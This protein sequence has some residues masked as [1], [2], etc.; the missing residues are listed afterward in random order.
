MTF[1]SARRYDTRKLC[2][3]NHIGFNDELD[4]GRDIIE[5]AVEWSDK[6]F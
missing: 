2:V 5:I 4:C 6:W 3:V 1:L